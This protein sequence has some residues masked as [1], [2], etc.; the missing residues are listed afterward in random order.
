MSSFPTSDIWR[1]KDSDINSQFYSKECTLD[2]SDIKNDK[3]KTVMKEYLWTNYVTGNRVIKTLQ[4]SLCQLKIF[5]MF[6]HQSNICTLQELDNRIVEE[7]RSFLRFH[8]SPVTKKPLTYL[9]QY[10][11][12]SKLKTIIDWCRVFMPETVPGTQIFTGNEYGT[13]VNKKLKINFIPDEIL[14]AVNEALKSEDNLYLKYG[15]IIL[16]CTGMR[17]C[18]MLLLKTDCISEHPISGYTI[19]WFDYK[20]RKKRDNMPV[21]Y[22]CK[23]AVDCL[24]ALTKAVRYKADDIEKNRLFIYEPQI[25][26][27]TKPVITVPKQS[28][29]KWCGNFSA[30]HGIR[31][32]GGNIYKI[33]PH[34]FRRT[35]ATDMLSK[36]INIKVIQEAL[37]HS[38]PKTTKQYYADVKDTDMANMFSKIGI[39]GDIR[40]VSD[41][42]IPEETDLW[43]FQENCKD[44]ARLSDG[45]C[46]LPIQDGKPCGRFLSR[47]KCYLCSRYITTLEDLETH[48]QHLAELQEMLDSN[49]YGAHFAAHITPTT[50]ALKEII[51]RLEELQGEQ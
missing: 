26:R 4:S 18:D 43:W 13:Q 31:D 8:V 3:I 44:K 29:T 37:G 39:L 40:Q 50:L 30:K 1:I 9:T 7:Y 15:I 51:S 47:Q 16:E 42:N 33:T 25:G 32:S 10:N 34:M 6:C 5:D 36:G 46:T 20:N 45:Y 48:R 49:I 12:F 24:I 14:C 22:E 2:F 35:L 17:I 28:F 11:Y 21:P 41:N 19:S 27:N 23:E 38:S